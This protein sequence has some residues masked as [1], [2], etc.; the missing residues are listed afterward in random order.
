[1]RAGTK[2]ITESVFCAVSR[3]RVGHLCDQRGPFVDKAAVELN[4]ARAGG[5][6]FAC[7]VSRQDAAGGNDWQ[8]PCKGSGKQPDDFRGARFQRCSAA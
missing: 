6:F 8:P 4:Q 3:K 5:H 2:E 1:M 7:V